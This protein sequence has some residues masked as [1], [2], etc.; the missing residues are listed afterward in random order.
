MMTAIASVEETMTAST[1]RVL[2]QSGGETGTG[3]GFLIGKSDHVVTN[4]HVVACTETGG[5]VA[6]L[7]TT[8]IRAEIRWHSEDKDLAILKL[9]RPM[10]RAAVTFATHSTVKSRD[11]VTAA[12]FPGVADSL[13]S[14]ESLNVVSLSGGYI[15]RAITSKEG[16]ALYQI[17]AA[18]NPGN[19][20]GPLFNEY[21]Q[22]IGINVAKAL[23]AVPVIDASGLSLQRL[24]VGEGIGW[25]IQADEL[26][27][28]LDKL[29]ISYEHETQRPGMLS[30]LWRREQLL[31]TALVVSLL[32]SVLAL[33]G[34]R[35][36]LVR[37]AVTKV[38]TRR[39]NPTPSA[40]L[41]GLAGPYAGQMIELTESIR[42]G[43]DPG[44]C[45]LVLSQDKDISKC[46]LLVS[47]D[48]SQGQFLLEDTWSTN[49]TYLTAADERLPQ[50]K[51]KRVAPG[52][53]F[54]LAN[55]K[56]RFEVRLK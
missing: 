20:G 46:H 23:A 11:F 2:C 36:Q 26:L 56:Y 6:L 18:I 19:S 39:K 42:I 17:D 50:G 13:A 49:G 48:I 3:S 40:V 9:E 27:P 33:S 47:Y 7:D 35:R 5:T 31:V 29:S 15:S 38:Y 44:I 16:V 41:V 30:Q 34:K 28:V 51:A 22:V 53:S 55:P 54:Y 8:T 52:T 43:R 1:V 12:G 32:I 25:A 10:L 4:W 45:Q 14:A 21:G 37:E 24:P